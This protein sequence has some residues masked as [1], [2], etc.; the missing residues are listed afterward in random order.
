MSRIAT[1]LVRRVSGDLLL[2]VELADGPTSAAMVRF[3]DACLCLFDID[4]VTGRQCSRQWDGKIQRCAQRSERVRR[5]NRQDGVSD[6]AY[7]GGT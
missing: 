7:G 2:C 6:W 3:S 4:H 1:W 5:N